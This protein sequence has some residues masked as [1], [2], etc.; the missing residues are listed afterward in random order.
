[1]AKQQRD[2]HHEAG[3]SCTATPAPKSRSGPR[4]PSPAA[5]AVQILLL[6]LTFFSSRWAQSGLLTADAPLTNPGC[7]PESLCRSHIL[8]TP[9]NQ[10]ADYCATSNGRDSGTDSF[11]C[12]GT[13]LERARFL[14][15]HLYLGFSGVLPVLAAQ[16]MQLAGMLLLVVDLLKIWPQR[17]GLQ[18]PC[19]ALTHRLAIAY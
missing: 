13:P 3:A 17:W 14:F 11:P 2:D 19:R 12:E 15:S 18:Q 1:M 4:P 7:L 6:L 5:L 9:L 16:V 8:T 10:Q